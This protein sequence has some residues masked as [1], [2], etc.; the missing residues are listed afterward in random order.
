MSED[1][2][3]NFIEATE[4]VFSPEPFKLWTAISLVG[5]AVE[6]R[7][8]VKTGYYETFPNMYIWL[9]AAPGVGKQIIDFARGMVSTLPDKPL[10][11]SPHSVT[12]ASLMDA[13]AAAAG[14][15]IPPSGLPIIYHSLYVMTEE[16]QLFMPAYDADFLG[17]LNYVYNNPGQPVTENR[18]T[19]SVRELSIERAQLNL[20]AGVQPGWMAGTLPELAW[21]TGLMARVLMVYVE[22]KPIYDFFSTPEQQIRAPQGLIKDMLGL[23]KRYG[24]L[25]WAP[26]AREKIRRWNL[27]GGPPAPTH[28]K[29]THYS[30]RR[31]M[32][33]IKLSLVSALS[34]GQEKLVELI[35]LDRAMTWLFEAERTMPDIFRAMTGRS[36]HSVMEE[37]HAFMVGMWG[38]NKKPLHERSLISFL[39]KHVPAEKIEKILSMAERANFIERVAGTDTYLPKAGMG[40]GVE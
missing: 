36:D 25:E 39:T 7:A 38:M 8:W 11:P 26:D 32:H 33:L 2:I 18:R 1:F 30:N 16:I 40:K 12:K 37:L 17:V 28:S 23:T 3:T 6:R 14:R 24:E 31:T 29:L 13:L 10:K 15:V 22:D 20:L 5:A 9:V 35:D 34:R 4:F 27:A 21:A 19:G